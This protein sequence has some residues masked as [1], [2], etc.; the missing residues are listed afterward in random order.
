MVKDAELHSMKD[1]ERK[2]LI[3]MK[4][5]ADTTVYSVEKSLEEY[6]KKI[7]AEVVVEIESAVVELKMSTSSENVDE[8]KAKMDAANKAV[9]KIGEHMSKGSESSGSSST[10]GHSQADEV[11]YEEVNKK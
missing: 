3:D 11:E 7:P 2:A 6:R 1:Q 9:S 10:G 8:I 4:N 5:S